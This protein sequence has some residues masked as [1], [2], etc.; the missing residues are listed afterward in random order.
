MASLPGSDKPEFLLVV[1]FTPRA[2]DNLVGLMV[3]HCDGEELGKLTV[4]QL[5]KQELINGPMQIGAK[6]NQDQNISKDLTLWN[7]Q[8]SQVLRGQ[9]LVLPIENTFLYVEPIYI[10]AT[11]ARMPQLK[12]VVLAEGNSLIY[13]DSYELALAQLTGTAR[14]IAAQAPGDP[15]LTSIREHLRRYRELSSQGKW[16]DAGK[17]LEAIEA[18]AR[19]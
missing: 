8:G 3:G 6:V 14:A 19:R 1:P 9:M 16:A 2:K 12:K 15:R 7:Q 10:Q 13:A 17:E 4:L 18:E 5:S 11:E